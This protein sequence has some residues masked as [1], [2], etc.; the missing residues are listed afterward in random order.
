[1]TNKLGVKYVIWN[2]QILSTK[3]QWNFS[4]NV[5]NDVVTSMQKHMIM[6]ENNIYKIWMKYRMKMIISII[7]ITMKAKNNS[8]NSIFKIVFIKSIY[9]IYPIVNILVT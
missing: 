4:T 1:M 3:K 2:H 7:I 5:C 8:E 6:C 9:C